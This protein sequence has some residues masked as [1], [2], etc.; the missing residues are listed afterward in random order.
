MS[1]IFDRFEL[2][3]IRRM[4]R[5][6]RSVHERSHVPTLF[7]LFDMAICILRDHVGYMEYNLFDFVNKDRKKRQTYVN[8]DYSQNL[9][10]ILNDPE[11]T[12]V[13][14]D[15]LS[16]NRLFRDYLGRDFLDIGNS[17]PED[18][19]AFCRGKKKI[20]AKP[21]DSCSGKGIYRNFEL[22]SN[23][24]LSELYGYL[25][26]HRLFVEDSIVQHE[27]MSSLNPGSI[28]TVRITTLLKDDVVHVMYAILRIGREGMSVDNV[29][30][31]GI[32][33]L[34]SDDGEITHPCWSDKTISAY[35]SHP[36]SGME[37]IGFRVPF[38]NE[39]VELCRKAAMVEKH[40]RYVGWDI[41]ITDH[42][43]TIVEGNPLPGYDMPQNYIVSGSDTGLK[44][45]FEEIL[46]GER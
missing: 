17:T 29:G 27:R 15:K 21:A 45:R 35:S 16:F 33:T 36:D 14:N 13:F 3:S 34:L 42:G 31:G 4:L 6:A 12:D 30:S 37:L 20:F 10:R 39:A 19:E 41:A 8:F 23:T 46:R 22:D 43:P 32:Y 26:E 40:V 11:H 24:D 28:N 44:P 7:I 25:R 5:N 38:F 9:F 1:S 2:A 18:F